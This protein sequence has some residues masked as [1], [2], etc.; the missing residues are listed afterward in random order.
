MA[1][2]ATLG[3]LQDHWP[4]LPSNRTDE[5]EQKLHE[6]SIVIRTLYPDVDARIAAGKLSEEVPKLVACRMVKR[7]MTAPTVDEMAGINNL[8]ESVG[9][10]SQTLSFT[11]P[12]GDMYLAKA[13]KLLLGHGRRSQKAFTIHP[14]GG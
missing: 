14:G 4:G 12:N 6:A 3:D 2:F 1:D 5:A 13:D 11:N 10:V 7:A 8:Q 9:G